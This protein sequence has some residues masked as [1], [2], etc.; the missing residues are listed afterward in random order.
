MFRLL[1]FILRWELESVVGMNFWREGSV[2]MMSNLWDM[3]WFWFIMDCDVCKLYMMIVEL[4]V[5]YV[6]IFVCV[7]FLWYYLVIIVLL[8][9]FVWNICCFW[10]F[11]LGGFLMVFCVCELFFWFFCFVFFIVFCFGR[12]N[13]FI[14]WLIWIWICE[15][16]IV[17]VYFL[18]WFV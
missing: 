9:L 13:V 17:G 6:I 14:Y 11:F 18:K 5:L 12:G 15:D 2:K 1:Y 3:V 4:F 8:F 10:F 16:W 7:L